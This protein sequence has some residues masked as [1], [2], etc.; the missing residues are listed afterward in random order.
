[1][2]KLI[3]LMLLIL[4]I[5]MVATA[6]E[7]LYYRFGNVI[8]IEYDTDCVTVDDGLGNL[9]EYYGADYVFFGDLVVMIMSDNGT[10][11]WIYDDV[12]LGAYK[13]TEG[14][15]E[16]LIVQVKERIPIGCVES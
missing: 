2:K 7:K 5:P 4:F 14:E 1:M 10:D 15:A 9:W 6:E 11:D 12:I 3:A 13:C 8:D 16:E